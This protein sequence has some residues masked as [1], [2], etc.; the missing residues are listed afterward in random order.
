MEIIDI[1]RGMGKTSY[2]IHKSNETEYPILVATESQK[3]VLIAKAKSYKITIPEPITINNFFALVIAVY[4][5]FLV[6]NI[7]ADAVI[8]RITTSN[9]LP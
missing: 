8:G 2:L 1:P 4:N 9:S 6:S 3:K 7:G 5:R